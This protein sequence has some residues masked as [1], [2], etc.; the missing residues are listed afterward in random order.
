MSE[1]ELILSMWTVYDH[2][3]DFPYGFIA[4]RWE[5]RRGAEGVIPTGDTIHH[6]S[7]EVVRRTIQEMYPTLTRMPRF[8]DDDPVIIEVWF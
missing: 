4:R 6:E 8:S 3:R 1:G 5:I 7:L 2:P